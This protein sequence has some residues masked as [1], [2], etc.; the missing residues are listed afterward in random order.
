[1]IEFRQK[2]NEKASHCGHSFHYWGETEEGFIGPMG[3]N[4]TVGSSERYFYLRDSKGVKIFEGDIVRCTL[5][6][7]APPFRSEERVGVVAWSEFEVVLEMEDDFWPVASWQC[8]G[9]VEVIGNIH[10]NKELL[11]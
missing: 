2:L 4:E 11:L 10:E 7:Q 8:V 1:M 9:K 5:S 3:K 6:N